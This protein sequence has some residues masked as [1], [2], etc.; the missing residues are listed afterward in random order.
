MTSRPIEKCI[1]GLGFLAHVLV[2]KYADHMPVEGEGE[3]NPLKHGGPHSAFTHE[4]SGN[5][6]DALMA[7][8]GDLRPLEKQSKDFNY[9][10]WR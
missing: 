3:W 6:N 4:G 10:S 2:I 7:L 1:P 5:R 9:V 8:R